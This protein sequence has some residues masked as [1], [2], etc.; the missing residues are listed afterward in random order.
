MANTIQGLNLESQYTTVKIPL[1]GSHIEEITKLLDKI[2]SFHP[3]FLFEYIVSP[4]ELIIRSKLPHLWRESE[5]TLNKLSKGEITFEDA[6]EYVVNTVISSRVK[7]MSTI[8][9]LYAAHQL[10]IETNLAILNKTRSKS[11][12]LGYSGTYNRYYVIGC[13]K[14]SQITISIGSSGDS[15]FGFKVQRDKWSTNTIIERLNLPLPQWEIIDDIKDLPEI[16][17]RFQ[18]PVV[19]KPTGLVGGH[20]VVVGVDTL[21]KAEKAFKFGKAAAEGKREYQK[22]IMIQQQIQGEDYRLLV[23]DGKLE[24]VTK[25]IPAFVIGDGKNTIK[26]LIEETNKDPRRDIKNPAHILK[27]IKIDEPLT[28][29]LTEQG[30][31]LESIPEKDIKVQ[32]R[33]VASMSQGGVTED[34][35]DQV[36]KE[37]RM[38]AETIAS[39]THTFVLGVDVLCKDISKPLTPDN[40]G[41]LEI[42]AMPESYLNFFP[43]IGTQRGYVAKTYVQKL[44]KENKTQKIVVVGQTTKHIPTLLRKTFFGEKDFTIGEIIDNR[45]LINGLEVNS[46][47]S[48]WEQVEAIK[49]NASLDIILLHHRDWNSVKEDGLGFDHIDT[50]YV[51]KE[52]SKEKEYMKIVK[53]YRSMKL[54]NKIVVI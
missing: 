32:V 53:K 21:E 29:Y 31:T 19:I 26:Q 38:I 27:P 4:T 48:R 2:N 49:C 25:R 37:I 6:N 45:Y 54:I 5:E 39:S 15:T 13:G 12:E 30:Y 3:I 51:T 42:N 52:M 36:G 50:L 47:S 14:G 18:K 46:G 34:F 24:I 40:G 33:K 44:L 7:S 43:T 16:W 23:V 8:P 20:G 10:N 17:D 35:T 22:K 41:I 1:E 28:E 9:V 11:F